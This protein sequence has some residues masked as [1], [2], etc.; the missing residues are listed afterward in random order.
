MADLLGEFNLNI[1][2]IKNIQII[3]TNQNLKKSDFILLRESRTVVPEIRTIVK[4]IMLLVEEMFSSKPRALMDIYVN[5]HNNAIMTTEKNMYVLLLISR[6]FV[7]S[8]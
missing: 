2:I 4:T 6:N 1:T 3:Q 7:Y 8:L 5:T